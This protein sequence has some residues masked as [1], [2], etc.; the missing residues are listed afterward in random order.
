MNYGR[1]KGEMHPGVIKRKHL[2]KGA[3]VRQEESTEGMIPIRECTTKK[4]QGSKQGGNE[5]NHRGLE[6]NQCPLI[7]VQLLP[8]C[9]NFELFLT[10]SISPYPMTD[11]WSTTP[12]DILDALLRGAFVRMIP[13]RKGNEMAYQHGNNEHFTRRA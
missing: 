4:A 7:R 3:R 13:L 1:E 2:R 10:H 9:E 6:N 12:F 11:V 8:A 5:E